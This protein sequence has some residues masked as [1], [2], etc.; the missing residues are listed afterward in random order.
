[1]G[2]STQGAS[3]KKKRLSI[4]KLEKHYTNITFLLKYRYHLKGSLDEI[5]P[6]QHTLI[7]CP[8]QM[9]ELA[10]FVVSK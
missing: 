4:N 5:R 2:L 10:N 6:I 1:M 7:R 9:G 8:H 3:P